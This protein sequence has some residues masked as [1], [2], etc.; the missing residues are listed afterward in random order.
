MTQLREKHI[1]AKL[2]E[3]KKF[4]LEKYKEQVKQKE[5]DYAG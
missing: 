2:K 1:H 3:L 4:L 5:K